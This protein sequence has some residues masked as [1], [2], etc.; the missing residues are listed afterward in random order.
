MKRV[1]EEKIIKVLDDIFV[2]DKKI[3]ATYFYTMHPY[4]TG[5]P[6][7]VIKEI[8]KNNNP[9]DDFLLKLREWDVEESN[10]Y[11][12][13]IFDKIRQVVG[14]D[15]F[16]EYK[17]E[18]NDFV[19]ERTI[20]QFDENDF[21]NLVPVT[22]CLD[23]GNGNED[24]TCDNILN[25][26]GTSGM[27]FNGEVDEHSSA[28]WLAKQQGYEEEF[29]KAVK[30]EPQ[31]LTKDNTS[32]FVLS[33]ISELENLPSH[34]GTITFLATM[35]FLEFIKCRRMIND[36]EKFSVTIPKNATCGLYNGWDGSGSLLE[37]E[38]DKDCVLSSDVIWEIAHEDAKEF[39]YSV[40]ETYGLCRSAWVAE[41]KEV[42]TS[43]VEAT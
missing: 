13:E 36:K 12:N 28:L 17:Q 18:I 31:T 29:L 21:N 32:K 15:L 16:D 43:S 39:G 37:I 34:M 14:E 26:Y 23:T 3:G 6:G 10:Y 8:L 27:Y 1:I 19:F 38:L 4:D 9:K 42:T 33:L 25:Y 11:Y 41:I 5:I 22:I 2:W 35:P 40:T 20:F 30:A 24:F 7:C